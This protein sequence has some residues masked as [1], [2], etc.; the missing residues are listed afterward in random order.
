MFKAKELVK[1]VQFFYGSIYKLPFLLQWNVSLVMSCTFFFCKFFLKLRLVC[2]MVAIM[3]ALTGFVKVLRVPVTAG[4]PRMETAKT[5]GRVGCVHVWKVAATEFG[6][7]WDNI[8]MT[9]LLFFT[10]KISTKIKWSGL[11][12]FNSERWKGQRSRWSLRLR[13]FVFTSVLWVVL[14]KEPGEMSVKYFWHSS[15]MVCATA[16]HQSNAS[17]LFKM[18]PF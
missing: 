16:T 10:W 12:Q 18:C 3:Q 1:Y 4:C 9:Q 14:V 11:L 5:V 2:W 7:V 6:D 17:C 15:M 13:L 8:D